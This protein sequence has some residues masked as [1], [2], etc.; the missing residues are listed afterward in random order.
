MQDPSIGAYSRINELVKGFDKKIMQAALK[1]LL[2]PHNVQLCKQNV[3]GY[4]FTQILFCFALFDTR[5]L[6]FTSYKTSKL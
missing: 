5:I 6:I 2:K 1:V 4:I 3:N